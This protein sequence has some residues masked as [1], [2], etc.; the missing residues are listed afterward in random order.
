MQ[1]E[2][3]AAVATGVLGAAA[4][5]ERGG[6]DAGVLDVRVA[7]AGAGVDTGGVLGGT[8]VD[9]DVDVEGV[10]AVVGAVDALEVQP[11]ASTPV[12]RRLVAAHEP[13]VRRGERVN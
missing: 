9:V 13:S 3:G 7:G 5:V 4:L 12:A 11:A 6:V 8:D 2:R 10:G 1:V